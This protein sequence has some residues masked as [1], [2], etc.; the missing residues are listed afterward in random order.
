MLNFNRYEDD[1]RTLM[2]KFTCKR[3]GKEH[4]EP[5]EAHKDDDHESY[6]YL[7]RIKP[8]QGWEDLPAGPLLCPECVREY[9]AFMRNERRGSQ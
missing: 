2:V 1:G 3:C 5:M 4:I 7:R 9:A 6:G 8:P